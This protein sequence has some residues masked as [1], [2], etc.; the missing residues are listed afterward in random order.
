[1]TARRKARTA[2]VSAGGKVR[3]HPDLQP[4]L[5]D[6]DRLNAHP[7]NARRHAAAVLSASV[8]QN[9]VY[10]PLVVNRGTHTGRP[11]EVL[12]GHGTLR[13]IIDNGGTQA[14][15]T[16]VDVNDGD[17]LRI[18]AVDNRANDLASYDPEALSALLDSLPDLA[19]TGYTADDLAALTGSPSQTP[20][21]YT[22]PDQAERPTAPGATHT[23]PGDVWTLGPHRLLCGDSTRPDD[24]VT[25]LNGH[26]ADQLWTD[27]PY[28]VSYTGGTREALTI[29]NDHLQGDDL[30]AFL[31]DALTPALAHT[32][33]GASWFVAAPSGPEF[34]AFARVLTE[35]G[36]WRQTLTW[37]KDRFVLGHSDYHYRHEALLHG[38]TP[39][40]NP[41]P[42]PPY[43]EADQP[44]AYGWTPGA[45]HTATP[46]RRQDT[47][48]D[49]P[50][51]SRNPDHPTMKPVALVT[52]A[53]TNHTRP[54]DRIYDPF[55]GSGT[56]LI[57]AHTTSRI[58]HL[59]ENDPRYCDAIARRWTT[60]TRLPALLN[61]QPTNPTDQPTTST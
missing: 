56:T 21:A 14:P 48:W 59:I 52:R 1:M 51:P 36:V 7:K 13:A 49:V 40:A 11:N 43:D 12:A 54:G 50:R 47:V 24:H 27:P 45:P 32:R 17:A 15:V 29:R 19:G 44:I 58:A 46:D 2:L 6:V 35:L 26:H 25:A 39:G 55:A 61:G 38:H 42:P 4:L 57:A 37:V 18:L 53:I 34:L 9:G 5:V 31:R 28:G 10:K 41:T 8:L 16:W 3:I 20:P 22:D 33:P 23:Q 60:H 30:T